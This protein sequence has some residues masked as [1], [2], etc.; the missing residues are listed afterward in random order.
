[1]S[2]TVKRII[3][4]SI[5]LIIVFVVVYPRLGFMKADSKPGPGAGVS[6]AG[7]SAPGAG[8]ASGG[9]SLTVDVLA[10]KASELSNK[11][12]S[13]GTVLANE[14]VEIRSEISG[15][16]T[17]ILFKEGDNVKKGQ[18]LIRIN[19][20]ELQAQRQKV[21]YSIKLNETQE[22]RQKKLLGKEAIS[23][24]EYD[25]ILTQLNTV[26]ADLQQLKAQIAKY[27]I[28]APFNGI[29]GLRYVSEGSYISPTTLVASMQ[30]I[31]PVKIEF[32]VSERYASMVKRGSKLTFTIN[33]Q[34]QEDKHEAEVYAV[35]PRIDLATRSVKVRAHCPN[36]DRK[37]IPGAFA[38]VELS[39]GS[40]NNAVMIP[41]EALIPSLQGQTVFI[42]K[43]GLARSVQVQTG[44]RT[45][46]QVQIM[47]GVQANDSLIV[48]GLLQLKDSTQVKVQVLE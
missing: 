6:S 32:N 45:D 25:V 17:Q 28:R 20:D 3:F 16:V 40:I 34:G 13:T 22:S 33:G 31:D 38:R 29:I 10:L 43:N 1:M 39:V 11:V 21:E 8:N 46:R 23:Q 30:D 4:L 36:P 48:T 27:T 47:Q 19:D 42:Y 5:G 2:Q 41:T 44:I 37:L 26:K 24:Q 12:L 15:K 18:V 7:A 35:E 14:E 9:S